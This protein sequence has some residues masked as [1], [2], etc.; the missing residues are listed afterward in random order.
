MWDLSSG[1]AVHS[2][3][4]I[5]SAQSRAKYP[6]ANG[7]FEMPLTSFDNRSEHSEATTTRKQKLL[8]SARQ[9]LVM[10]DVPPMLCM[11]AFLR[12]SCRTVDE[13]GAYSKM[14]MQLCSHKEWWT[15]CTIT[16]EGTLKSF[17]PKI[18]LLLAPINLLHQPQALPLAA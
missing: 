1:R 8:E 10:K 6:T 18:N 17:N 15:T 5:P 16:S 2:S 13:P 3:I 14:M 11:I 7:V 9:K 4:I 12:I